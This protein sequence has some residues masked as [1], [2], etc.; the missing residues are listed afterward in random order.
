M[1]LC[2][3]HHDE[4]AHEGARSR[5]RE[6][7]PNRAK[8]KPVEGK[9]SLW[10]GGT[11]VMRHVVREREPQVHRRISA[12]VRNYKWSDTNLQDQRWSNS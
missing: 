3:Q 6:P 8:T 2:T 5:T 10:Q 4:P 9:E 7:T 12:L 1:L 11:E